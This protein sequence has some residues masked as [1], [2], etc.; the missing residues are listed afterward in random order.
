MP[1]CVSSPP[2]ASHD[3]L[4]INP[5]GLG[6]PNDPI[7]IF[8]CSSEDASSIPIDSSLRKSSVT[9]SARIPTPTGAAP[10][11]NDQNAPAGL[12]PDIPVPPL[13]NPTN[14]PAYNAIPVPRPFPASVFPTPHQLPIIPSV[15]ELA[16]HSYIRYATGRPQVHDDH[17]CAFRSPLPILV[18]DIPERREAPSTCLPFLLSLL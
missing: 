12:N 5:L 10:F 15:S 13:N 1:A 18:S 4:L 7:E 6:G 16:L 2:L 8:D 11:L 9:S 3:P 17:L 14:P